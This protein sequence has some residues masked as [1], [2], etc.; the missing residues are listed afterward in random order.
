MLIVPRKFTTS[1]AALIHA[2]PFANFPRTL[3]KTLSK[4]AVKCW[5]RLLA[6]PRQNDGVLN[7]RT[8]LA[9]SAEAANRIENGKSKL[10]GKW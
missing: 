1:P 6:T 10:S 3:S 8:P 9:V 4:T 7:H 5:I 2:E